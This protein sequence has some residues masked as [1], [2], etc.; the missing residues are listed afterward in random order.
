MSSDRGS[1][2]L[3]RNRQEEPADCCHEASSVLRNPP[4]PLPLTDPNQRDVGGQRSSKC[5]KFQ[6]SQEKREPKD[7]L[8]LDKS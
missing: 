6:F 3:L 7:F 8:G 4:A 2:V 1:K 5:A